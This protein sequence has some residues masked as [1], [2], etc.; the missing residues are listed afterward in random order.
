LDTIE[1]GGGALLKKGNAKIWI[2][3]FDLKEIKETI[4]ELEHL[5][6]RMDQMM[7]NLSQSSMK[8][9]NFWEDFPPVNLT[10]D[11]NYYILPT[12]GMKVEER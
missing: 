9:E 7:N 1:G 2:C 12:P 10:E 6:Q 3:D 4:V 5:R 11:E 8:V